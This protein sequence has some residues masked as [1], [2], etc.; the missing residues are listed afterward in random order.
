MKKDFFRYPFALMALLLL[1]VVGSC[2]RERQ[3]SVA[4]ITTDVL[5]VDAAK[6]YYE[7]TKQRS[8]LASDY[9]F[10]WSLAVL[11]NLDNTPVV[12]V[13][14]DHI[15][16]G[17][18]TIIQGQN[19]RVSTTTINAESI[20]FYLNE[21][22]RLTA[23]LL[24]MSTVDDTLTRASEAHKVYFRDWVDNTLQSVWTLR[25]GKILAANRALDDS[26]ARLATC[27]I[28]HYQRVCGGGA[29]LGGAPH[30]AP[31][32]LPDPGEGCYWRY[33]GSTSCGGGGGSGSGGGIFAFTINPTSI[34]AD[35]LSSVSS[36][37][38]IFSQNEVALL[39]TFP[40]DAIRRIK[41]F[42]I[43]KRSRA[44]AVLSQTILFTTGKYFKDAE[45]TTLQSRGQG[46]YAVAYL[47]YAADAYAA[48][49]STRAVYGDEGADCQSCKGNAYKHALFR[50]YDAVVFGYDMAEQLGKDHETGEPD[51][52]ASQMDKD[53]NQSGLNIFS[54]YGPIRPVWYWVDRTKEAMNRGDM[55]F[56]KDG[57]RVRS[58]E[59]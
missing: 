24:E 47:V 1:V 52:M 55:V 13:P 58:Y 38:V 33:V 25:G 41:D 32:W 43:D 37:G 3:E 30:G 14:L 21:K 35:L 8:K 19:G 50:I 4:P 57:R 9:Q 59:P 7:A 23:S 17:G 54:Q 51:F 39:N 36:Y 18:N 49:K 53:N 5:S 6:Q 31:D 56:I 29:Q 20:V 11:K 2:Q 16:D 26:R 27:T 15:G 40:D 45:R 48:T 34:V 46:Y 42:L 28:E 22:G 12:M 44:E 10:L